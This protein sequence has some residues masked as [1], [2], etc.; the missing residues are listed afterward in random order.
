MLDFLN[1]KFSDTA[2]VLALTAG[3][4]FVFQVIYYFT[5]YG[6]F[7]S[8]FRRKNK[9][10]KKE[11]ADSSLSDD[12][13]GVSVVIVT[14]N[15]ADALRECLIQLLEQ[16]YPLFEVV[17]VN[18]NSSDDT[19]FILYVL[20]ENYPSLKVINLGQNANKFESNKFSVAIG[21]RSAKFDY[22]LLTDVSCQPKSYDWLEHMMKPINE[23]GKI[24]FVT[25]ICLR[26][27]SSGA[28][29]MLEKYDETTSYVN[30]ISYT[31]LGNPYTSCGMNMCY[32]KNFLIK[33]GCFISQYS[34]NCNQ[35]DYLVHRYANRKNTAVV[36]DKDS[37]LYLPAYSSFK[38]FY[39]CKFA[40]SLSHKALAWKDKILL[41]IFPVLSFLFYINLILLFIFGFPWQYIAAS[42]VIKWILHM[43]FYKNCMGKFYQEKYWIWSPIAEIFFYFFNFAVRIKVL[44]FRKRQKKIRWD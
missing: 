32:D 28:A 18:E 17:V 3:A 16:D 13:K 9:Q 36:V 27:K 6:T 7:L 25:G 39:R 24:K 1:Y 30:L 12:T 8:F 29:G 10:S 2:L 22:V 38:G 15:N 44:F 26:E 14:N 11:N 31:L 21:I 35:E 5:V 43:I 40:S 34:N 41:S 20:Q 19:E 4:I 42:V 37:F 23:N 33:N